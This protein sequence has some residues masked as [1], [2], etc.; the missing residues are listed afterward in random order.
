M[1]KE[2]GAVVLLS[3]GM[4][5]T[6]ALYWAIERYGSA[7]AITIEYG[8]RHWIEIP[9]ARKIAGNAYAKHSHVTLGAKGVGMGSLLT[10]LNGVITEA[11]SVVPGRNLL[12]LWAGAVFA[13]TNGQRAVVMGA[14]AEDQAGYADC[15]PTTFAAMEA[16]LR[17]GLEWDGDIVAPYINASKLEILR[18]AERMGCLPAMRESWSCY[19]P[20]QVPGGQVDDRSP[21]GAC[22]ACVKRDAAWK[23]FVP[24][25]EGGLFMSHA[26][27]Q[28]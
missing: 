11:N 25:A 12:F 9:H 23:A 22:P 21:C 3:G 15:R 8:Q 16:A 5:S 17:L 20:Q 10:A 28:R 6:A 27:G 2:Q 24:A 4:D 14:C 1:A 7:H 18:D 13:K 26:G 19:D